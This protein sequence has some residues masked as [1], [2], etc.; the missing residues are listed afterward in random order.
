MNVVIGG[1]KLL[2]KRNLMFADSDVDTSAENITYT[3]QV[4]S[5]GAFILSSPPYTPL[6]EFTQVI[7]IKNRFILQSFIYYS[8]F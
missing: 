5:N 2:T 3:R 4:I 7:Y 1:D 8:D 6:F